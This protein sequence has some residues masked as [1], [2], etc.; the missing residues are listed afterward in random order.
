MLRSDWLT[1]ENDSGQWYSE[2]FLRIGRYEVT[3]VIFRR[4][5]YT[6]EVNRY[7]QYANSN[8]ETDPSRNLLCN[9][10]VISLLDLSS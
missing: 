6:L 9:Q 1:V 8:I 3:G 10:I 5:I 2:R 7:Q 4:K